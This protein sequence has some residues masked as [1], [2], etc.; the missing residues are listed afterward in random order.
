MIGVRFRS[1]TT[2]FRIHRRSRQYPLGVRKPRCRQRP[3]GNM[4]ILGCRTHMRCPRAPAASAPSSANERRT[5]HAK[6]AAD[7]GC[8]AAA[9]TQGRR[10]GTC[11]QGSLKLFNPTVQLSATVALCCK[12]P[13]SAARTRRRTHERKRGRLALGPARQCARRRRGQPAMGLGTTRYAQCAEQY[14]AVLPH[15]PAAAVLPRRSPP[16]RAPP[17]R[18]TRSP[19]PRPLQPVQCAEA[20][21]P[22][23]A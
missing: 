20:D 11:M 19:G 2:A 5:L 3:M 6:R 17:L 22:R 14:R 4:A 13:T 10:G 21:A 18:S 15:S 1:C 23:R 12:P 8:L 7:T 9:R 16:P